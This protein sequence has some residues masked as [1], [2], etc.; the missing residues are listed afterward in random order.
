[1]YTGVRTARLILRQTLKRVSGRDVL[2]IPLCSGKEEEVNR[3]V[4]SVRIQPD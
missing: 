2:R 4:C 3:C 1:M